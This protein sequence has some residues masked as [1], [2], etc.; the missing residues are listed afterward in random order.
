[1]GAIGSI[2]FLEIICHTAT[3]PLK[4]PV[5]GQSRVVADGWQVAAKWQ[6]WAKSKQKP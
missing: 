6:K 4:L 2:F 3:H 5:Y 1:M